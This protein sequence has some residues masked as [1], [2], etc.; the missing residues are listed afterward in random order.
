[1]RTPQEFN[2]V[3]EK[4]INR[5]IGVAMNRFLRI[6][7]FIPAAGLLSPASVFSQEIIETDT[8]TVNDTVKR[9]P[10]IAPYSDSA[11]QCFP[12]CRKGYF[13]LAGV[14]VS[15][16]NPPC[17]S[18]YE[19]N[20]GDCMRIVRESHAPSDGGV[21]VNMGSVTGDV[22]LE[23]TCLEDARGTVTIPHEPGN[24]LTLRI[25]TKRYFMYEEEMAVGNRGFTEITP[26]FRMVKGFLA[27]GGGL[28]FFESPEE[29]GFGLDV[30]FGC[31]FQKH[32][33]SASISFVPPI[34][35]D[36]TDVLADKFGGGGIKYRFVGVGS[37]NV[38]FAP[39]I[40][41]G[42]W[43]R[44]LAYY[45]ITKYSR[46][47]NGRLQYYSETDTTYYTYDNCF[48]AVGVGL[49]VGTNKLGGLIESELYMGQCL[50]W[51]PFSARMV[52]RF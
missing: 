48:A 13:C 10:E 46:Y 49:M 42:N 20:E 6:L 37:K 27:F 30:E 26:Y 17:P 36:S 52:F 16:C 41:L 15:E 1:M 44:G 9:Q 29:P 11:S 14:C 47:Y 22:C 45:E 51:F 2:H 38:R 24:D 33:I 39:S 31:A 19:C 4:F 23:D 40:A 43:E 25:R 35:Y 18:G 8:G 3:T 12:P 5:K 21:L 32:I 50:V 34:K 28:T 7:L